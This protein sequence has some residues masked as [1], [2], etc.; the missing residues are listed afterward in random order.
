MKINIKYMALGIISMSAISS[1]A[2]LSWDSMKQE[3]K[4]L[5]TGLDWSSDPVGTLVDQVNKAQAGG[6]EA[7][8]KACDNI[9]QASSVLRRVSDRIPQD[10]KANA[11]SLCRTKWTGRHPITLNIMCN[12][13]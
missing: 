8:A 6:E 3:A 7:R 1:Y 5:V 4:S 2:A 13:R 10:V 11:C 12:G 9:G